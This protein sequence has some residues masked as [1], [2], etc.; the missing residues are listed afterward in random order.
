MDHFLKFDEPCLSMQAI[1][2]EISHDEMLV[3][4]LGGLSEEYSHIRKI[5]EKYKTST[6]FEVRRCFFVVTK[7]L[8]ERKIALKATRNIEQE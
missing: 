8:L 4:L 3:I 6:Y 2:D 1:G 7:A 5:I